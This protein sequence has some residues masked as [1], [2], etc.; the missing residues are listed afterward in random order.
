MEYNSAIKM[1]RLFMH[2]TTCVSIQNLS[3]K[4]IGHHRL[5]T[6]CFYGYEAQEQTKLI[7]EIRTVVTMQGMEMV[8][9]N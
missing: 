6:V 8:G 5:C 1:N 9:N 4:R 7:L 3:S 2:A